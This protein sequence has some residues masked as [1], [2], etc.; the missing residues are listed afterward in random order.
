M[1]GVLQFFT[2]LHK[3]DTVAALAI[4]S[5]TAMAE[6]AADD[7]DRNRGIIMKKALIGILALVVLATGV[8]FAVGQ[9]SPDG[10]K[11]GWGKRGGHH[12]GMGMAFRG[13]DLTDEQKAKVKELRTASRS[14]LQPVMES[15][16]AN[17][18]KMQALTANGAFDEA[19]VT[20][21]ANEQASLSAKLIVERQRVKSQ[22]FSILTDEQKAKFAEMKAKGGERHKGRRGVRAEKVSE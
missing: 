15:L 14:G 8:M 19:Q 13:L 18:E 1:C 16:K 7:F 3:T 22:V 17:R 6:M 9:K 5:N 12:R 10:K 4:S 21:L 11:G 2:L 20:A